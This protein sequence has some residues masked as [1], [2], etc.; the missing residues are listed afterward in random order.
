MKLKWYTDLQIHFDDDIWNNMFKICFTSVT[1][2]DLIWFQVKVIYR[3]LG[4]N[5][6][7]HKLGIVEDSLCN[8]CG[9]RETLT[10]LLVD[11]C[12][13]KDKWKILENY[14]CNSINLKIMLERT[15]IL[16]GYQFQHQNRVPINTLLL[17]T[18]KYIFDISHKTK[19]LT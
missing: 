9:E 13:V 2:N 12:F 3:L 17:V 14:V 16:L 10:H 8:Q 1:N 15:E 6:Y 19:F 18:K 11:C 7:L 5:R 4:T